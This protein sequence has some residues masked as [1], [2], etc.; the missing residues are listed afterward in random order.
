MRC[1]A[2]LSRNKLDNRGN[3]RVRRLFHQPVAGSLDNGPR[4]VS[5]NL[6]GLLDEKR[7]GRLLAGENKKRHF[8]LDRRERREV[9][10]VRFERLEVLEPGSH[11]VVA[12]VGGGVQTA[13][14][15]RRRFGSIS[16]KI[17]PEVLE[18][19]AFAALDERQRYF[20]VKVGVSSRAR[21]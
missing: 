17:V 5:G 10:R 4:H 15:L 14:V 20:P 13:I 16:R 8:E 7:A 2:P 12:S 18:V 21:P 11:A 9:T 19:D 6:P 1:R 3:D